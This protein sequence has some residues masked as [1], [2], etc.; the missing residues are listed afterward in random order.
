M[1]VQSIMRGLLLGMFVLVFVSGCASAARKELNIGVA[2]VQSVALICSFYG[3]MIL[4][5]AI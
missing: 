1:V 5:E 4:T 3:M 2:I